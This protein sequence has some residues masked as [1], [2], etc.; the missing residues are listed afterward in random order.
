MNL[1]TKHRN[2]FRVRCIRKMT[3]KQS[4]SEQCGPCFS[5]EFCRWQN[6]GTSYKVTRLI[7][8]SVLRLLW[9]LSERLFH[10]K[11]DCSTQWWALPS[12]SPGCQLHLLAPTG[13]AITPTAPNHLIQNIS[14]THAQVE[15]VTSNHLWTSV[16]HLLFICRNVRVGMSVW[17]RPS[18]L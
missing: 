12:E 6:T 8:T 10:S 5:T 13:V 11:S 17:V 18:I 4:I 16:P 1:N 7:N 14:V 9:S 2:A 15:N 3:S